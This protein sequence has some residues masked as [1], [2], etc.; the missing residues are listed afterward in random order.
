MYETTQEHAQRFFPARLHRTITPVRLRSIF[1]P[2]SAPTSFSTPE[3]FILVSVLLISLGSFSH[4][5]FQLPLLGK[6]ATQDA[7]VSDKAFAG[8]LKSGFWGKRAVSL[9]T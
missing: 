5:L 8:F 1:E 3:T 2:P 9:D 6:F 7:K 4:H